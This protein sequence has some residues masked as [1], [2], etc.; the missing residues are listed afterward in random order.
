MLLAASLKT[1]LLMN[2]SQMSQIVRIGT[3]NYPLLSHKSKKK[4]ATRCWGK[5][6][7]IKFLASLVS[8]LIISSDRLMLHSDG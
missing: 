2:S 6:C 5:M 7:E 3:F 1:I 8:Y 4:V